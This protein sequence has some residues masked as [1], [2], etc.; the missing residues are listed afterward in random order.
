MLSTEGRVGDDWVESLLPL[1]GHDSL[2]ASLRQ[3]KLSV[4]YIITRSPRNSEILELHT[5][6]IVTG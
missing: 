1:L 3:V 4:G 5:L 2:G 6:G